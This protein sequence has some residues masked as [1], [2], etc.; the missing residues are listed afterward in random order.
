MQKSS[1]LLNTDTFLETNIAPENGRLESDR[2]LLGWPIFRC[3]LLVSGSVASD[4][5][6]FRL[7]D[8]QPYWQP[9]VGQM[10]WVWKTWTGSRT[11]EIMLEK[12]SFLGLVYETTR[13]NSKK[14][15]CKTCSLYIYIQNIIMIYI[16]I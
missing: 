6:L 16:Y 3:E 8:R 10:L 12:S 1:F 9:V 11:S 14:L 15:A 5:S 13:D 7:D 2:F 4:D